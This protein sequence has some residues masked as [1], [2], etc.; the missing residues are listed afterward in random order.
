[1][2][3]KNYGCPLKDSNPGPTARNEEAA[4]TSKQT[5]GGGVHS[6]NF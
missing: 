5:K 1:M 6:H 4:W 2:G 3:S